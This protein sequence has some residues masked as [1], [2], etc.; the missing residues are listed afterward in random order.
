MADTERTTALRRGERA[1]RVTN[2]ELFF[3]LVYVF[4]VT[5]LSHK[6]VDH[7]N[8][9][10]VLQAA[11][12]LLMVWQVWVYTTWSTNYLDPSLTAVRAMLLS[13]MLGSLIL[14]AELPEA[15]HDRGL[16]VALAY[17]AMQVGRAAF[18]IVILRG[19]PLQATY[20]RVI[21]WSAASGVVFITGACVHG[22]AR[23]LLWAV[24]IAAD[25]VGSGI[26]FRVP[27]LGHS[28]TTDWTVLGG[29]FAERCQAFVL[30]ALGES[31][32]V[33]GARLSHFVHPDGHEIA[34]FV[35]AF[36]GSV[37][38]WWI[39]FDR[40]AE[41]STAVIDA[42]DDPGK[43]A[44]NAFHWIHPFIV[45]GI[46]VTA[47]AD[48]LLLDGPS[49]RGDLTTA[50]LMLGGTALFLGG[51]AAF[52]AMVWRTVSWPRVGGAV[53][54]LALFALAPH[55]TALTLGICTLGVIVGVAI[56]DRLFAH[57]IE[58]APSS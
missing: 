26:G 13:L 47:A 40:S 22:H 2:V 16:V 42:S 36:A 49:E 38:L 19:E 39:Y 30:I 3:D 17:V 58:M 32:V 18:E 25:L 8:A 23:E 7:V 12:L 5:Q 37:G 31:I 52:K 55:V 6:L 48:E 34:G 4:A 15:F 14:A 50:G 51:H 56:A 43:L 24:A 1:A 44:R 28:E 54:A 29:H 21:V 45:G 57:P 20:R 9:E 53:G 33:I 27:G 46:I 10:G 35:A 41:D 11:I